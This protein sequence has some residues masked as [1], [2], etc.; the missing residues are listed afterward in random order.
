LTEELEGGEGRPVVLIETLSVIH[1]GL[2]QNEDII[3]VGSKGG[4]NAERKLHGN[5]EEDFE[6][7]TVQKEIPDVYIME[8]TVVV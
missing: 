2:S 1:I 5:D 6:P 7:T 3:Y 8:P 4:L